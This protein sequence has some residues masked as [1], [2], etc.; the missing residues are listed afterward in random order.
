MSHPP[1]SLAQ[2]THLHLIFTRHSERFPS[3]FS[4]VFHNNNKFT[5]R[6]PK[7][8]ISTKQNCIFF[9]LSILLTFF[10]YHSLFLSVLIS[11]GK[12]KTHNKSRRWEKYPSNN[13]D[14]QILWQFL[15]LAMNFLFQWINKQVDTS[16]YVFQRLIDFRK[17]KEDRHVYWTM[18]YAVTSWR[19]TT[20]HW[21]Y[22]K[23]KATGRKLLP[24]ADKYHAFRNNCQSMK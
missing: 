2:L 19:V 10:Y 17:Q 8:F 13:G 3:S 24:K 18:L 20:S 1:E 6:A 12:K 21:F 15:N 4:A 9:V 5:R 16:I 7:K 22:Y 23:A 11:K 14:H